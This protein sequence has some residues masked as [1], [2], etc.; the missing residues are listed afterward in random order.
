M[1]GDESREFTCLTNGGHNTVDYIVGSL[2]V[3]Q[4]VTHFEVIIDDTHNSAVG[5][6]FDHMLLCLRLNIDCNFVQP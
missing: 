6:D 3:W 2:V 1:P 4:L 5:G